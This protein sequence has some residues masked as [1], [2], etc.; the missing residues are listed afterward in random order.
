[1]YFFGEIMTILT[2]VLILTTVLILIILLLLTILLDLE[3]IIW[4]YKF[5]TNNTLNIFLVTFLWMSVKF[6]IFQN[7]F[8]LFRFKI[9][10]SKFQPKCIFRWSVKTLCA[11]RFYRWSINAISCIF[12]KN[13]KFNF[14]RQNYSNFNSVFFADIYSSRRTWKSGFQFM[15]KLAKKSWFLHSRSIISILDQK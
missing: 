15:I 6:T 7:F 12:V 1:M 5:W 2:M 9:K 11:Q 3:S 14:R 8:K 4:I 13:L 10:K